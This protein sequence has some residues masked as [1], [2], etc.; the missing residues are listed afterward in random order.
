MCFAPKIKPPPPAAQFQAMQAPR[1][2]TLAK[3]GTSRNRR[4]GFFASIFTGPSGIA[5]APTVT[6]TGGG[7]T[8][9]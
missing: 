1:D 9:G 6:G 3:N 5:T 8:G 2:M 4:R 7:L